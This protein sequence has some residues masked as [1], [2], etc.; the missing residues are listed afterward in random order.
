MRICAEW[1]TTRDSNGG[2]P[3]CNSSV[4]G[5]GIE[6]KALIKAQKTERDA[7]LSIL[8]DRMT[9]LQDD[10]ATFNDGVAALLASLQVGVDNYNEASDSVKGWLE[11][12]R[13][14]IQEYVDDRSEKWQESD[15]AQEYQD[16]L[17]AYAVDLEDF[18]LPDIE[19]VSLDDL[20]D[21]AETIEQLPEEVGG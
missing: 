5:E 13:E 7:L 6:M 18:N 16:W 21:Y 8:R 12:V 10:V 3:H 2:Q 14:S 17:E 1:A 19:P 9:D 4:I 11:S 15:K 20:E